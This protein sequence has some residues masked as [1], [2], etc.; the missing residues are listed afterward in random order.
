MFMAPL[1]AER[2][3][4]QRVPM[5]MPMRVRIW[6]FGVPD[7]HAECVNVSEGGVYFATGS[8]F[9]EGERVE[10]LVTMPK[11]VAG[12][13]S[14]W[15]CEGQVIRVEGIDSASRIIGVAVQFSRQRTLQKNEREPAGQ[16]RNASTIL[17]AAT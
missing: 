15:H 1:V 7:Q 5:R 13:P 8:S 14:N 6:K 16:R 9:Q 10:L 3:S 4:S 11:E 17:R 2:R 12:E